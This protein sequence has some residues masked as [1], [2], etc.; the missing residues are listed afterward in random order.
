MQWPCQCMLQIK[1]PLNI[2]FL[3]KINNVNILTWKSPKSQLGIAGI[4]D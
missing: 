3:N 1:Q 2:I 4:W